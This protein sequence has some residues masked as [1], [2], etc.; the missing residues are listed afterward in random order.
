[1]QYK[2]LNNDLEL[3]TTLFTIITPIQYPSKSISHESTNE[4]YKTIKQL[5]ELPNKTI[6]K[7]IAIVNLI[8]DIDS[9]FKKNSN[10]RIDKLT[11]QLLDDTD[12]FINMVLW[13]ED[14]RNFKAKL[15][16]IIQSNTFTYKY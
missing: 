7:L 14:A 5:L 12:C 16:Q 13:E 11:V 15:H 1:M 4:Q 8:N 2:Q 3:K 6:C 10:Q 9:V